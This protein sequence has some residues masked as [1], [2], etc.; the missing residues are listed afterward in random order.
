MS[1]IDNP[2]YPRDKG[3]LEAEG[4]YR[5]N[6]DTQTFERIGGFNGHGLSKRE[7]ACIHCGVP[8]T[9]DPELDEI[10]AKGN[11]AGVYRHRAGRF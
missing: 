3:A 5:W 11:A 6:G 7:Y 2:A 8:E 9:G 1:M 4:E 10:I